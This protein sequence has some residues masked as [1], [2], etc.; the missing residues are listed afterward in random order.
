MTDEPDTNDSIEAQSTDGGASR[1]SFMRGAAASAAAVVSLG[2]TSGCITGSSGSGSGGGGSGGGGSGAAGTQKRLIVTGQGSGHHTYEIGA[3]QISKDASV[4]G[5]D[6]ITQQGGNDVLRGEL[7]NSYEDRYTYTGEIK[8]VEG[9]GSLKFA[10]PD[11]A[12]GSKEDL[13]IHGR[14]QGRHQ[15]ELATSSGNIV[16]NSR[17]TEYVDSDDGGPGSDLMFSSDK[18][19][20]AIRNRNM[21]SY[22]LKS[23]NFGG[24]TAINQILLRNGH[25]RFGPNGMPLQTTLTCTYEL[26]VDHPEPAVQG[27]HTDT[28]NITME[29]SANRSQVRIL[30]IPTIT[31]QTPGGPA[32]VNRVVRNGRQ[33]GTFDD[34]TGKMTVPLDLEASSPIGSSTASFDL[35]TETRNENGFSLSGSRLAQSTLN[36]KLVDATQLQ[37]G[38]LGGNDCSLELDGQ[39]SSSPF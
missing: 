15:Y 25:L 7:W 11:D 19:S 35:T 26:E 10:F 24:E 37:S 39:L 1:R 3:D 38:P 21:D 20:G 13:P 8:Y 9:N 12:F 32:T 28:T 2:A 29:F 14:G 30:N 34:T 5:H 22:T 6:D 16:L 31:F 17:T 33:T 36:I 18:V 27:P 4:E 23:G